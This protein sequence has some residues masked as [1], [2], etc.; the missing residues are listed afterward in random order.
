M[1][2]A[3]NPVKTLNP[4]IY[5]MMSRPEL[6]ILLQSADA[7]LDLK[8]FLNY[9]NIIM[10]VVSCQTTI[11]SITLLPIIIK[12]NIRHSYYIISSMRL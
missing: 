9:C 2:S 8:M 3:R 6:K 5:I 4:S 12:N 7:S 1:L 10:Q 11:K